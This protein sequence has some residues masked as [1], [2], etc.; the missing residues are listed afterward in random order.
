M[1][2]PRV[3]AAVLTT[4]GI[5][6]TVTACAP[7]STG[8]GAR[9]EVV[10]QAAIAAVVQAESD[11]GGRAFE[12]E[13]DSGTA[14]VHVAVGDRDIE[15]DVDLA[16]PTVT[17]RR[18]D[19][20]LDGEDRAALDAAGTTLADG[21]RIAAA[22][23]SASGGVTE[24]GVDRDADAPAWTVEFADGAEVSVAVSDGSVVRSAG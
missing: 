15:V 20:S 3:P 9:D 24:A 14:Q 23:R 8:A 10:Y 16:G 1:A 7:A 22:V 6:I 13:I 17:E 18:D 12:L 5:A 21:I 19:G 11:A 2:S 4:L